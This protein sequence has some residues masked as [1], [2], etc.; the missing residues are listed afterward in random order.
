LLW[1][2]IFG[3]PIEGWN[4][5]CFD[6]LLESFGNIVDLYLVQGSLLAP[7]NALLCYKNDCKQ[8]WNDKC[9]KFKTKI[10]LSEYNLTILDHEKLNQNI[11]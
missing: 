1:I 5:N 4:K 8:N 6:I 7:Q 3:L 10:I 9:W 2:I 11:N